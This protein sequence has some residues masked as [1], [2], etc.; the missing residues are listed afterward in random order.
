MVAVA[1]RGA[2]GAVDGGACHGERGHG[3]ARAEDGGQLRVPVHAGHPAAPHHVSAV[4]L[5]LGGV[6]FFFSYSSSV[7]VLHRSVSLFLSVQDL[8][9]LRCFFPLSSSICCV[10]VRG[11]LVM[12]FPHAW[13]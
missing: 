11:H 8:V 10:C 5:S 4:V 3:G 1:V 13:P 7:Q 12:R 2:G 9:P 6:F